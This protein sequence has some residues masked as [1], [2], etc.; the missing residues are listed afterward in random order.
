VILRHKRSDK[1]K[2]L[3]IGE[4]YNTAY[5]AIEELSI[6]LGGE[7]LL[8]K[9][10]FQGAVKELCTTLGKTKYDAWNDAMD[11]RDNEKAATAI[12]HAPAPPP[13]AGKEKDKCE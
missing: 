10:H 4:H 7:E 13:A 2:P 9:V 1:E 12:L 6:F 3:F 11:I 5:D 8:A